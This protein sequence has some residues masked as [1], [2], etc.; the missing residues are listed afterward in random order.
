MGP[1]LFYDLLSYGDKVNHTTHISIRFIRKEIALLVLMLV[2]FVSSAEVNTAAVSKWKTE[3]PVRARHAMVVSVQHYAS[4]AGIEVL[5]AGG[6]AVDAAVATRLALAVVHP[7]A[8][9]LGGGGF[10]L[11]RFSNAQSLFVDYREKAPAAASRNMYLDSGG[12]VIPESSTVGYRAIGVPGSVAGMALAERRWGKLGWKRVIQPAIR[13]AK[14]GF[15]LS[16][17]EA[18]DLR[19]PES[20][21]IFQRDGH[22]YQ[23]GERFKQPDL[24]RTLERLADDPNIFYQGAMAKQLAAVVQAGGG[25]ITEDDLHRYKAIVRTPV[26]G[27]YHDYEILSAPLPSSGGIVLIEALNILEPYGI[28]KLGDRSASQLHLIAEAW[29][30][31][32]M[33]RADFLGDPDYSEMP[34]SILLSKKYAAAWR[35]SI[36]TVAGL[37]TANRSSE[38]R[39]P[40][41]FDMKFNASAVP[42][43][44]EPKETTHYSV[45]DAE[46]NAVSVTTTLNWGFGSYVTATGLGFLLNNQMDDFAVKQGTPNLYGLIQGPA[47]AIAAGKRPLSSMTPTIILKDGKVRM[48]LGSP[49]GSRIITT[50]GNIF[51]GVLDG[52]NIQQAVD[53]PRFHM[54]YQPD[55][56][57]LEPGFDS[58][59]ISDL[60]KMGYKVEFSDGDDANASWSDGECIY[61]DPATGWIEGGQDHRQSYGKAVGY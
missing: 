10:M 11:I 34:V 26:S 52:L 45:I 9:N 50:V 25:L 39:R 18:A 30:R 15:L 24:E 7:V 1:R 51:L 32:F 43:V 19:D 13:L 60:K 58:A 14:D 29:R 22:Y 44:K 56:L 41:G 20:R 42:L 35:S 47:N 49:G 61:V 16:A 17:E 12:N 46:G 4:D 36:D 3:E 53:A 31:A 2:P 8:G 33:D 28:E 38:L 57:Y 37:L 23:A 55:K 40:S 59:I 54:Q 6:N 27:R 48:I 5:K 21:R